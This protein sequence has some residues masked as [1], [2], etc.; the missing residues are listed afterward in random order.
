MAPIPLC[1]CRIPL[2]VWVLQQMDKDPDITYSDRLG[3]R[4]TEYISL[5]C[6]ILPVLQ[7]RSPIQAYADFM[8]NF[9]DAFRSFFGDVI[10]V[11]SYDMFYR[12]LNPRFSC[13][14]FNLILF[15]EFK[16]GWVLLVN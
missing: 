10:T 15:R 5:G 16:L 4:S 14:F 12:Y 7:G 9:R 1:Y 13:P 8:R 6:D 11:R 3:R 2:P